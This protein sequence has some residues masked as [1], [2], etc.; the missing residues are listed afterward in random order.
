MKIFKLAAVIVAL[1]LCI[2]L[3]SCN[4][5][6]LVESDEYEL[7]A[8]IAKLED[9]ISNSNRISGF[10][11]VRVTVNVPDGD[12][13]PKTIQITGVYLDGDTLSLWERSY[14]LAEEDYQTLLALDSTLAKHGI[15]Y[16]EDESAD[17]LHFETDDHD[18]SHG[19]VSIK[20]D[21]PGWVME[22]IYKIV[23]D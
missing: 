2:S 15:I 19:E 14:K 4:E 23:T 5:P 7:E 22:G 20:T 3:V 10:D 11:L 9:A 12:V 8:S 6:K 1:L 18:H 17:I 13:A 16:N 21:T